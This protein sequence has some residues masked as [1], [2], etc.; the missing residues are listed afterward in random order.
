MK[1]RP[2][3]LIWLQTRCEMNFEVE[4]PTPFILMLRPRNNAQQWIGRESYILKPSVPVFEFTDRFGNLCQRLVA[5]PGQF[6]VHTSADIHVKRDIDGLPGAPFDEVQT[7][8]EEVLSYLLP[9]RYCE[10]DR[11]IDMSQEIVVGVKPGYDQ[12][13]TINQWLHQNIHFNPYSPQFQLSAV[14]TYQ[15]G[16]GHPISLETGPMDANVSIGIAIYPDDGTDAENLMRNADTA[17]YAAKAGG[18]RQYQFF[19]AQMNAD[20]VHNLEV[21]DSLRLAIAHKQFILHYQ[22]KI[23]LDT[24]EVTGV[25]ALLR[26]Q[27]PSRG[28]TYPDYFITIA[29]E[30]E[31]IV[32]IGDWVI[33]QACQQAAEWQ[34]QG[35]GFG[36]IAINISALQFKRRDLASLVKHHLHQSGL[37]PSKL[38]LELT[39]SILIEDFPKAMDAIRILRELGVNV[40]LD[41]FGTG[42]SSLSYLSRFRLDKLK[43][44]KSFVRNITLNNEHKSLIQSIII[45]GKN[46]NLKTIAEGVE[47]TE[48]WE[49]LREM[50]CDEM[51]GYLISKPL[52]PAEYEKLHSTVLSNFL[53]SGHLSGITGNTKK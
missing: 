42:H 36:G 26:W 12:V 22:P 3:S 48:E 46:H 18:R 16:E 34:S 28:L 45:I 30:S 21:R 47:T 27:H 24:R 38:E 39:E 32:E 25:E 5:P 19:N 40:A 35:L 15:A 50:G 2:D 13:V 31:L 44:D 23:D 51:Q 29:E 41:D 17:L 20:L 10:S 6:S 14:E 7:L 33:E 49:I 1:P 8:P 11:F 53:S 9:T 52:P 4:V 37:A 43:I